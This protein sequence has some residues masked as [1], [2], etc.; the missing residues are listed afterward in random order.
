MKKSHD[1]AE[2]VRSLKSHYTRR[3]LEFGDT[4]AAAQYSDKASH[5]ERFRYLVEIG[6]LP[7]DSVLDF[8]CGTGELLN[9]LQQRTG[10]RGAYT[11]YEISDEMLTLARTKFPDHRFENRDVLVDPPEQTYDYVLI[12]GVFNNAVP[13]SDNRAFMFDVLRTLMP[14]VRK[15]LAFNALSRYV[16]YFDSGLYYCDPAEV[17]RFCKEELSPLV[18]L[19]HDYLIKPSAPPF[20]FTVYVRPSKHSLRRYKEP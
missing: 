10:Y 4:P 8:G 2:L 18:T 7:D 9:Y 15:G 13:G 3:A 12:N 1:H 16:D 17:F 14:A 20:E 19:R 6:V 5:W 11:G